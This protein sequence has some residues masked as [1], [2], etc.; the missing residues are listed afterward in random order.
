MLRSAAKKAIRAARERYVRQNSSQAMSATAGSRRSGRA[1]IVQKRARTCAARS[2]W[3]MAASSGRS[4]R[5]SGDELAAAPERERGRQQREARTRSGSVSAISSATRPPIE[6]PTRW[7]RS[8]SISSMKREHDAGEV[9]GVVGG[10]GR[11]RGGAEA[12]QVERVHRVL[13]GQRRDRLEERGL[14]AAEPV[15]ADDLLGALAGAEGGDP[16][17]AGLDV[18]DADQRR[19]A[20]RG[21]GRGPRSRAPGRGR[22]GRRGGDGRRR[23]GPRGDPR[24]APARWP[25]R[26]RSRR[27][28]R[29][30]GDG[31][32][33]QRSRVPAPPT[34][35]RR[36]RAA[37]GRWRRIRARRPGS[38]SGSDA[39]ASS[40]RRTRCACSEIGSHG[41]RRT[42][43]AESATETASAHRIPQIAS[44]ADGPGC[45]DCIHRCA[46]SRS[47]H[48]QRRAAAARAARAGRARHLRL[49][50]DDLRPHPRRQRPA[51]RRL[52]AAAALPRARGHVRAPRH[53]RHRHQRQ[54]L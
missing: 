16:R 41:Q 13:G 45:R 51:V 33:A 46:R 8:I 42:L 38:A 26:C 2:G 7:A 25:R 1:N 34:C 19:A 49:R 37:P 50:A 6:L 29:A 43:A 52:H 39:K 4:R 17:A 32:T 47:R 24:A 30:S 40:T 11:L 9:G 27:R 3:G 48:A 12:G 5:T 53:Q 20:R 35:A 31:R 21:A 44:I 15:Q 22:R 14:V 18:V 28:A 36:R 23:R 10:R 54:D